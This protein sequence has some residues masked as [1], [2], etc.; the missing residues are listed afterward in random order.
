MVISS[1]VL[2]KRPKWWKVQCQLKGTT[3]TDGLGETY[4]PTRFGA[5]LIDAAAAVAGRAPGC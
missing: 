2:G 4:D 3:R 1:R 5:G